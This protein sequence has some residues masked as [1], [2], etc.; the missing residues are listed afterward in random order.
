MRVNVN[1]DEE[2]IKEID[3]R[4]KGLHLSRSAY[5]SMSCACYNRTIDNMKKRSEEADKEIEE[6]SKS[7]QALLLELLN[8]LKK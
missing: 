3:V 4:A 7:T 5:I 1:L 8:E 2:L 6:K